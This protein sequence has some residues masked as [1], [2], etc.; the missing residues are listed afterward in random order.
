MASLHHSSTAVLSSKIDVEKLTN[1]TDEKPE[2]E[3]IKFSVYGLMVTAEFQKCKY[4]VESFHRCYPEKYEEPV[5]K[6][7]LNLGWNEFLRNVSS[8]YLIPSEILK[9][10]SSF[11]TSYRILKFQTGPK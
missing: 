1:F 7:M 9:S 3:K 2:D 11:N 6:P 5:I 10:I 4:I 8:T